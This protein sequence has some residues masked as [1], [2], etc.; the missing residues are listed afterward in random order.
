MT[1][2]VLTV[3]VTVDSEAAG[4]ELAALAVERRLA[5]CAQVSSPITSVYRWEG[6]VHQDPEWLVTFKTTEARYPE[7]EGALREAHS[8][9]VP[10]ILATPVV[11]G[12]DDYLRWVAEETSPEGS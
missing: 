2:G 3:A 11:D 7:L 9:D 6:R 12:N 1:T 5:A 4:R 10:E 8:Y